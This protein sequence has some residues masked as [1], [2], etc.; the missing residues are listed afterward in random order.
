MVGLR[1]KVVALVVT[2]LHGRLRDYCVFQ[3]EML[4]VHVVQ[5]HVGEIGYP[6]PVDDEVHTGSNTDHLRF[7]V[8]AAHNATSREDNL[9][10]RQSSEQPA[11]ETRPQIISDHLESSNG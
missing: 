4:L 2:H 6:H 3:S 1:S 10:S 8:G 5:N 9:S 11:N 7:E